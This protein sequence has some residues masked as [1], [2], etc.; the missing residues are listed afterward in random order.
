MPNQGAKDR[1]R[2]RLLLTKRFRIE[3]RTAIQHKR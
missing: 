3:S 2:S 1:K